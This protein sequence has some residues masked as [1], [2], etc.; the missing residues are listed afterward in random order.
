MGKIVDCLLDDID[1]DRWHAAIL[2]LTHEL[3][4]QG[5]DLAQAYA[6][7]PWTA[8]ALQPKRL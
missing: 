1:I 7:T 3:A 5:A 4:S 2:A 8:E 6:S